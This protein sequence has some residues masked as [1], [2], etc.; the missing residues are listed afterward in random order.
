MTRTPELNFRNVPSPREIEWTRI[1]ERWK[2]SGLGGPT[3]RRREGLYQPQFYRWKRKFQSSADAT[4]VART[5]RENIP[6]TSPTT[7]DRKSDHMRVKSTIM[8]G[9]ASWPRPAA[10]RAGIGAARRHGGRG[11]RIRW[12]LVRA[13]LKPSRA[14][15]LAIRRVP[16][17]GHSR[18]R[19][20]TISSVM[21]RSGLSGWCAWT[22]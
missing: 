19:R 10:P 14:S 18:L 7:T 15:I 5:L 8:M 9:H 6:T 21:S 20:R 1:L 13:A 2:R 16:H 17:R 22:R 4:R 3:F 12:T 11:R